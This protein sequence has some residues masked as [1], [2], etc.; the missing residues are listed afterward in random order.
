VRYL[1]LDK[2]TFNDGRRSDHLALLDPSSGLHVAYEDE[3]VTILESPT[4]QPKAYFTTRVREGSA[5]TTLAALQADPRAVDRIVTVEADVGDAAPGDG[6]GPAFTVPLAAYHPNGLR[7]SF[8]AP[9]PGLFVVKDSDF[10][11]WQATLNG[12]PASVVAVNGLVRGV[13]VPA[14]GHYDLTMVYRP[15][16]FVNGSLLAGATLAL[17][18]A[19]VAW[20]RV[21]GRRTQLRVP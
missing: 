1:V 15:A 3:F 2:A 14:A 7:A 9:G 4:A 17:L 16:S 21:R 12:Q 5:A 20:D 8:D 11:G 18:L 10:P 6:Q 13:P 19:I